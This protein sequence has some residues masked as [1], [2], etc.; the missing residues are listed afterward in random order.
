[1]FI[2]RQ[3]SP[4]LLDSTEAGRGS[5]ILQ[6]QPPSHVPKNKYKYMMHWNMK[7]GFEIFIQYYLTLP[8]WVYTSLWPCA[9]SRLGLH[10]F[11]QFGYSDIHA[12]FRV[13]SQVFSFYFSVRGG[14][15]TLLGQNCGWFRWG[16]T[17]NRSMA[18][19]VWLIILSCSFLGIYIIPSWANLYAICVQRA[20]IYYRG[21]GPQVQDF[22]WHRWGILFPRLKVYHQHH[23]NL[24]YNFFSLSNIVWLGPNPNL[25]SKE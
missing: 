14:G 16:M 20:R 19:S 13:A 23:G 21:G 25:N 10:K 11:K 4:S 1:M 2:S 3:A 9:F 6:L 17:H 18:S 15:S 7:K 5:L 12:L 8:P 24:G 22:C